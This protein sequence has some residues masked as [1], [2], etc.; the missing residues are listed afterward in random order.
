MRVINF[1]DLGEGTHFRVKQNDGSYIEYIKIPEERITC[2]KV[3]NAAL[4][5]DQSQKSQ[6][7]PLTGIEIDYK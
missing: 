5:S 3:F 7:M 1:M 2:C 6:M 4:L